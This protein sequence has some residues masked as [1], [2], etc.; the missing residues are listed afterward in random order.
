MEPRN[1][2]LIITN[3][4][5]AFQ[6]KT[7]IINIPGHFY[8]HRF[9][10]YSVIFPILLIHVLEHMRNCSF[11]ID[12]KAKLIVKWR[13]KSLVNMDTPYEPHSY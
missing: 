2:F 13:L 10:T 7:I 5:I 1:L 9:K 11:V 4:C 6:Y 8:K 3:F 12:V